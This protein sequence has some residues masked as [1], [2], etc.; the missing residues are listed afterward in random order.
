MDKLTINDTVDQGSAVSNKDG[1]DVLNLIQIAIEQ[2]ADIE[3]LTKLMDLKDRYDR[4]NAERQ[5]N[6]SFAKF[7]SE[8]PEIVKNKAVEWG[9]A[10][11]YKHATLDHIQKQ[12]DPVLS[13]H[14]LSYYWTQSGDN[15]IISITCHLR[16]ILG[17]SIKIT[18][19]A[20]KDDSGKKNL[21]QQMGSTVTYLKRYTLEGITGISACDD[22]DGIQDQPSKQEIMEAQKVQLMDLISTTNWTDQNNKIKT[23]AEEII[24]NDEHSA[25]S[26][27]IRTIKNFN[28]NG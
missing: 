4:Q 2:K 28:K 9:G 22:M 3:Y 17:H 8:K 24:A 13:R 16:H 15:G 20:P 19:S 6:E 18:L 25:Y 1:S 12:I 27:A 23:R 7:Q 11:S 10:T 26:K 21:I 14:G 5:F